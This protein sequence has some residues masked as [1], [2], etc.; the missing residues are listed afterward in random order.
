MSFARSAIEAEI[1]QVIRTHIEGQFPRSCPTCQRCFATYREYI[2]H[3][4]PVGFPVSYDLEL[5]DEAPIESAGNL[6]LANC[7][8]GSTLALTSQGMPLRQIWQVLGW[9]KQ[10]MEHRQANLSEVLA[11]VRDRVQQSA[12]A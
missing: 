8:C 7:A 2:H 1:I 10:E 9:I 12:L 11:Y 5:E 6:S 3:T 4:E